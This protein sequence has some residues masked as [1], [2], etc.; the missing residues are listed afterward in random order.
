[1]TLY[2]RIKADY[3]QWREESRKVIFDEYKYKDCELSKTYPV[4][5]FS[6]N[7]YGYNNRLG[8]LFL[9]NINGIAVCVQEDKEFDKVWQK[10]KRKLE[11]SRKES[12]EYEKAFEE[13]GR[14]LP[15]WAK[16]N[17]E[18]LGEFIRIISE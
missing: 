8:L 12:V 15:E 13:T 9:A 17:V 5:N 2:G 3:D 14:E 10:F 6:L 7:V 18:D 11:K 4:G 1:M 16:G